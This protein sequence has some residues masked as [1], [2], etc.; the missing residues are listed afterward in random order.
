MPAR[1]PHNTAAA[2]GFSMIELI[3]VMLIAGIIAAVAAPTFSNMASTRRAMAAQITVRDLDYARE[4]AISS[5]TRCWV[6][7]STGTN[8]YSVLAEN[9]SS[10]GRVGATVLN[11]P[12][13]TGRTYVTYFSSSEFAGVTLQ[14]AAFGTGSEVGFDWLGRPYDFAQTALTAAGVVTFTGGTTVT[15]QPGT[16]LVSTP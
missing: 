9:P 5:G 12:A 2:R 16:G 3:V 6:V 4:R 8:S 11:D 13:S 15:V 14:S 7:F 1:R 10:P